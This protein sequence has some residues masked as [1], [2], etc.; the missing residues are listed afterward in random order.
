MLKRIPVTADGKVLDRL[1]ESTR[2][3]L[4]FKPPKVAKSLERVQPQR[5]R[6]R[7]SYAGQQGED[8]SESDGGSKKKKKDN[9]D[10]NYLNEDELLA[11]QKQY[12][13]FKPTPFGQV[14]NRRF[15]LPSMKSKDGLLVTPTLSNISLGIRPQAKVIP[16]PLHDPM[17]DHAIVLF[18]PTIDNRETDEERKEREA[19]EAKARAEEEAK[20]KTVGM[21]NPHKSLRKILGE[22]GEKEKVP[23]VPVVIDPQLSKVLRPHQIEGVRFLYKCTTGMVVENQYGCIMADEMGL[24]KTLQC[25]ALMWTLLRQSPHAGKPTIEKC[26]IACPSSLVKNW[27]NELVKWL[28]KDAIT[29]LAVDGKGGKAELLPKVQ[30]WVSARGRNVTQPVMI[31]SYET[32]RTLTVYLANCSIGLLLCDEGHRL[33]NSESQTFQAL[34][35]LD[36]RRRVIL[37]GTPIQNDL[38]EY[39]SLLNF[40]NPNF[41]GSKN[42]FR[43]NFENAIIRGRDSLASDETKAQSEK[44]LKELGS[45]VMK[46]IIRRT[47]DLLSKYLPVKYEQVVFCHLSDFQLSLYR[48]FITSP[49]I[50]ALLRGTESQPLK[51]INILKKLCNHPD[52]LSLPEDLKGSENFLPPDY[53]SAKGVSG[54][55]GNRNPAVRSEWGGKFVVLERFLH[56]IRTQTNDKIVLISNYTQTLDLFEKL[57]RNKKYG[58]FRLDG[59]M[60]ITKRQ[61]LVDQFNDPD[62]KEFVFLLSSKAG[63]CGINLIGA[64]RLILFD[65]DWNPA[66]DQQA[67]A[68]VWRDGQ[69]K[70]CFVYR[71]ISTGTIEEKIFQRQANKQALSSAVVDEKED[72]E[73]H[74][75]VD[76]LRQLFTFNEKTFC[77]THETFKCK[78]CKDGKQ[79]IK[80]P[81]LLYGDASTWN[82]FTNGEL[83]NNHDDLLRAEVGMPEVSFVFQYISH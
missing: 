67:L 81:A 76:A 21:Y 78:R 65:P 30:R 5:K 64:N 72:T 56:Q 33:K 13:V 63:G 69:K 66:A 20:V 82:H 41:L 7:V 44:K 59:T 73:R 57:C 45:L 35:S 58:F 77:D 19:E 71:F 49:E 28:G 39:F 8:D 9:R 50:K 15:S 2:V 62:G 79:M 70:E 74:F 80:S 46:F 60:S 52:L 48:L 17:E 47:N 3:N 53:I 29:P 43:K 12:P 36:V 1:Q 40:A 51:A 34:N 68:R 38:S 42:D 16:R 6:K 10:M 14:V 27:A 26:I 25:I 61:K 31:V 18:D 11:R 54:G 75:S 32:L 55:R 24:G 4:P 83:K 37:T 22:N 23:K